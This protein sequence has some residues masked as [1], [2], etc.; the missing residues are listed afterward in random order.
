MVTGFKVGEA[1][2]ASVPY[3]PTASD[4]VIHPAGFDYH[5]GTSSYRAPA[6]AY[7]TKSD[8]Y[9]LVFE[10]GAGGL[11]LDYWY[12]SSGNPAGGYNKIQSDDCASIPDVVY[13]KRYDRFLVV[14]DELVCLGVPA[15]CHYVIKGQLLYGDYRKEGIFAGSVFT[16]AS[17][18]G[19][20]IDMRQPAAAYN[21]IDYQYVVVFRYGQD[22]LDTYPTIRGQ[23]L[24]ASESTPQ[25]LTEDGND[26][27][28]FEIRKY[29]WGWQVRNP[30]AAWNSHGGSFMA[31]WQTSHETHDDYISDRH[32]Y[33]YYRSGFEQGYSG[34]SFMLAPFNGGPN[35]LSNECSHPSIAY[36]PANK[37]Y[38]LVFQHKEGDEVLSPTTI[39][40]QGIN[41]DFDVTKILSGYAFPVETDNSKVEYHMRPA[42]DYSGKGEDLYIVYV[43][44]DANE[45]GTDQFWL[46]ERTLRGSEVNPRLKIR[47]GYPDAG[48]DRPSLA[49]TNDG[50]ALVVWDEM[51]E[52]LERRGIKGVFLKPALSVYLPSVMKK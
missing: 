17:R 23:M 13:D 22:Y 28:G 6:A 39:H 7:S 41:A 43:S 2:P 20:G 10:D 26:L 45:P 16:I 24:G 38:M 36:D 30:D 18:H 48:M 44:W 8:Q 29:D 37:N 46:T 52:G 14:W 47:T 49:G 32:L 31:V 5:S 1:L 9:L 33:D 50:R 19:S 15:D 12:A 3:N 21:D 40:A 34:N 11:T 35:P 4:L 25:L 51:G 27:G 42:I